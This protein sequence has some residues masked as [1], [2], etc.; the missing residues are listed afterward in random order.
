MQAMFTTPSRIFP[1]ARGSAIS[2]ISITWSTPSDSASATARPSGPSAWISPTPSTRPAS[3][4]LREPLRNCSSATPTFPRTSCLRFALSAKRRQLVRGKVGVALEQFL[5]GSLKSDEAGRVDG[6]GEIHA[7]GPDGRA[8]ADAE[9]D[10]VDHVI[11]ILEIA[12]PRAEGNILEGVVNIAC[13][14][15][16]HALNVF[17]D[18]WKTQFEAVDQEGVSAQ[19]ESGRQRGGSAGTCRRSDIPWTGLIPGE[20]ADR[21]GSSREEPFGE[22]NGLGICQARRRGER[23][24]DAK[25]GLT[26]QHPLAVLKRMIRGVAEESANKAALRS[27]DFGGDIEVRGIEHAA[28]RI[29]GVVAPVL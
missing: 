4:D 9:S 16:Q 1:S 17:A 26:R 6:V 13:I 23:Q 11:E 18:E 25:L 15:E 2:R 20:C 5:S 21:V 28:V 7:D 27:Q 19:R 14:L 10:G 29:G 8:V 22:R 3:S 12:L 24:D